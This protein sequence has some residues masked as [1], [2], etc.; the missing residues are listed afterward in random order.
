MTR[1]RLL[2][3]GYLRLDEE[4]NVQQELADGAVNFHATLAPPVAQ[5]LQ[6]HHRLAQ[7]VAKIHWVVGVARNAKVHA[8][9][10]QHEDRTALL[11][12]GRPPVNLRR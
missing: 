5:D 12:Q 1:T 3:N 7:H 2:R 9:R 10:A 8:D 6:H 4:E 11:V